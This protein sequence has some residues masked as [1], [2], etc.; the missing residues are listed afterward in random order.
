MHVI[1]GASSGIGRGIAR[2][3]ALRGQ[4]VLAV[5]RSEEALAALAADHRDHIRTLTA[6]VATPEGRARLVDAAGS[7]AVSVVHAAGSLVALSAYDRLDTRDLLD[8]MA[9][10]VA[11]PIE[12]NQ[13]L[14]RHAQAPLRIVFVD[15]YSATTA[16]VG[17]AGYSIVKAAAQMAARCAAAELTG[18]RVIRVFPGA[19]RT[20]LLAAVLG[21][22]SGSPATA[23]YAALADEGK[24]AE[25][26]AI[27]DFVGRIL[28]DT[29]DDLLDARESWDFND[30]ADHAALRALER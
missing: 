15:S 24:V 8:D 10:H 11:A 4:P 20:P 12:I 5:A 25:P 22:R 3:L 19:V 21:D 6:D 26:E 29:P 18:A 14:L 30:T 17:W 9:V 23:T 2:T 13:R 27:G 1:T 16:R 7:A 28:I